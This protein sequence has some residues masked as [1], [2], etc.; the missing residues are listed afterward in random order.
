MLQAGEIVRPVVR[1]HFFHCVNV[2][3][4]ICFR[5]DIEPV[6]IERGYTGKIVNALS[7]RWEIHGK[8][9]KM[10]LHESAYC[11]KCRLFG[12][13]GRKR[14]YEPH[15]RAKLRLVYILKQITNLFQTK[16]IGFFEKYCTVNFIERGIFIV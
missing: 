14:D 5:G 13:V 4:I 2:K 10:I 16:S 1:E 6:Q 7:K 12:V 9:G 3:A 11:S 15:S 8:A